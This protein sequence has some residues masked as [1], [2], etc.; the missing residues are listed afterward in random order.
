MPAPP[1]AA[2]HPQPRPRTWREIAAQAAVEA[3]VEEPQAEEEHGAIQLLQTDGTDTEPAFGS[4]Q[5][6]LL[7]Y[8]QTC[9]WHIC[10]SC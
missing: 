6:F 4:L 1:P 5:G 8:R 3:E 10:D 2:R 9:R 7:S